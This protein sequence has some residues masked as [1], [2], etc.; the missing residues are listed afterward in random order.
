MLLQRLQQ[1]MH[2]SGY[3]PQT[4]KSY[5]FCARKLYLHFK[6]PLNKISEDDFKNFLSKLADK[7]YSPY[8]LNLY[9]AALKYI[10]ENIYNTPFTFLFPYAKRHKR[11]PVVLSRNDIAKMLDVIKNS[12]HRLIVALSYQL[13]DRSFQ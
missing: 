5:T 6:K 8:T 1:E 12:K 2:L 11:L 4:I 10:L 13:V 9:H 7:N 3:S